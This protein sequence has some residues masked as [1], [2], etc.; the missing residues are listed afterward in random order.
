MRVRCVYH[1]G[2]EWSWEC[3]IKPRWRL[4]KKNKKEKRYRQAEVTCHASFSLVIEDRCHLTT[5]AG[6]LE[7]LEPPGSTGLRSGCVVQSLAF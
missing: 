5:R 6:G 7:E 3:I 1:R 2:P 4:L